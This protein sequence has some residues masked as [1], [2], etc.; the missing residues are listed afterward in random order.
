MH[1][2]SVKPTD[3]L[4]VAAGA[5]C[6][7]CAA[8]SWQIEEGSAATAAVNGEAPRRSTIRCDNDFI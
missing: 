1:Y 8:N 2:N 7:T 5:D 4:S 6:R 3:A